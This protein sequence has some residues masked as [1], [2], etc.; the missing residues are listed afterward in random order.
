[1]S[2][3]LVCVLAACAGFGSAAQAQELFGV[4]NFGN[5]FQSQTLYR[6]N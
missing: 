4:G 3:K 2:A 6:I 5:P 1:M